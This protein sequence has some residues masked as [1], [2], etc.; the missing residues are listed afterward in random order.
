MRFAAR[1][2]PA[3]SVLCKPRPH[4]RPVS[5]GAAH[6]ADAGP[7]YFDHVQSFGDDELR[8]RGAGRLVRAGPA[9][10]ARRKPGWFD[11]ESLG[12]WPRNLVGEVGMVTRCRLLLDQP[13]WWY[14]GGSGERYFVWANTQILPPAR[15]RS[16]CGRSSR[17]G[18][19]SCTRFGESST[20]DAGSLPL[21]F[22]GNVTYLR[23]HYRPPASMAAVVLLR[24]GA[25]LM[26]APGSQLAGRAGQ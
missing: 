5:P 7:E 24:A 19:K 17:P 25:A 16:A 8:G 20:G 6:A 11:P 12:R 13:T 14:L 22:A 23:T 1:S 9:R 2:S 26:R 4:S 18:R 3:G 10:P 21:L 15:V